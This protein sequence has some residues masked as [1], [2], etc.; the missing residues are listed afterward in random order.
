MAVALLEANNARD[1]DGDRLAGKHTIAARLGRTGA[2]WLYV[3]SV[4]V[5]VASLA[6]AHVVI[7]AVVALVLYGPAV[8]VARSEASGRD[9]LVLLRYS[10]RAQLVVGVVAM[11]LL[12]LRVN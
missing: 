9:L 8:R 6:S 2:G 5:A 1:I 11:A 3:A 4:F 7:A 12:A 10:A